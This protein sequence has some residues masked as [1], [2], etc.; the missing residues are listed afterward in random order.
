MENKNK[1][2]D[3]ARAKSGRLKERWS[4]WGDVSGFNGSVAYSAEMAS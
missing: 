4:K 1:E 3:D 2:E